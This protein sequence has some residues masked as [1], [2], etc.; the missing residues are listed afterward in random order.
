MRVHGQFRICQ[1]AE[2]VL[3]IVVEGGINYEFAIQYSTAI[4]EA[5]HKLG[6]GPWIRVND[7]RHWDL[8]GPEV[9][10]PLHDLMVWAES[11]GLAHSINIV[12]M[13]NLQKHMLDLM[14]DGVPRH[15]ERHLTQTLEDTFALCRKLAWDFDETKVLPL[16]ASETPSA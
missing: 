14:M 1:P 2:R 7:I 9:I 13:V 6:P 4:Q 3:W 15:S 5:A 12:S 16:Y 11:S 10:P 8:C